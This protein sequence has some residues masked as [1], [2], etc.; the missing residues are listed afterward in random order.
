MSFFDSVEALPEDP[1]LNLNVEFAADPR[2]T[3]VNLGIG[4]Y[5]DAQGNPLVLSAVRKAE[6]ILLEKKLNKEYLPIPGLKSFINEGLKI[7]YGQN[8]PLLQN[9]QIFGAQTIGGTGALRV[10]GEFLAKKITKN[11]FFSRPTW[12]NHQAVFTQS[13]LKTDLFPYY[14]TVKHEIDF[15]GMHDAIQHMSPGDVI[16]LHGCCHNPT[17]MDPTF[18]EWVEL[19][20]L[21]KKQRVIPFFDLAYQGFGQGLEED[22]KP[23]R[24]F[25]EQGHE[26]LVASSFSKNF[27]LYGERVG[28]LSVVTKSPETAHC[29]GTQ[30]KSLIRGNYSNPP[31]HG[32]QIVTTILENPSLQDEWKKE[33]AGMRHR[34]EEMR[35]ALTTELQT[36][37]KKRDFSFLSKQK[38]IF[39]FSGL[40]LD[41]VGKLRQEK[42]IYMPKDGR[43]NVAGLNESNLHYVV[44]SIISVI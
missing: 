24:Y 44:E 5:K 19:S 38:G 31:S 28:L 12:P 39:S 4:A 42:G 2:E 32:A 17:G 23:I 36:R 8:S 33:L 3:K 21:I 20:A 22:V 10:A 26:M 27:G 34:I 6:A 35:K 29:L 40:S 43:M 1:I 18:E 15:S 9:N 41:Q 30:L 37:Q 11:L 7:I 13:G 25:V 14:N 16:L